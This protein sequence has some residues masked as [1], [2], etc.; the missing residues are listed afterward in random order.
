MRAK[1]L[2]LVSLLVGFCACGAAVPGK[3]SSLG[4]QRGSAATAIGYGDVRG[5]H[6][7]PMQ[8]GRRAGGL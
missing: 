8:L 1:A 5:W 4:A 3:G 2:S 6:Q 7:S